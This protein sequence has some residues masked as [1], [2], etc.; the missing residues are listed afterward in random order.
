MRTRETSLPSLDRW[1]LSRISWRT[2]VAHQLSD[3]RLGT[4]LS[5]SA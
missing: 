4:G 5:A 1:N 3:H 2:T